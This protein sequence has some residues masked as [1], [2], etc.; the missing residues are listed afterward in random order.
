MRGTWIIAK[1]D[2]AC[3]FYS[4]IAY[5]LLALGFFACGYWFYICVQS[6]QG[7]L[8]NFSANLFNVGGVPFWVITVFLTPPI[9]MRLLAEEKRTQTLEPLMT[10]PVSDIAVVGG[11]YLAAVI[12][13]LLLWT[14]VYI[15]FGVIYFMGGRFDGG[16]FLTSF[17]GILLTGCVFLAFG[18][19]AS[20]VSA[21]QIIAASLGVIANLVFIVGSYLLIPILPWEE[22]RQALR[23]FDYFF[24]AGDSASLGIFD[25]SHMVYLLSTALLFLFFTVRAVEVRKW[26]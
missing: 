21:N 13:Y 11:K 25:S 19:F 26:K 3:Y 2:L 14:P 12:M 6:F 9:T 22:A 1:K 17:L 15:G 4:P 10:A 7:Q 16:L 20:A 18:L 24:I 5:V 23:R 8:N